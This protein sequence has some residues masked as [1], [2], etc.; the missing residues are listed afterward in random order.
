[1]TMKVVAIR[2]AALNETHASIF[3]RRRTMSAMHNET[4]IADAYR[5]LRRTF[6]G[7][8]PNSQLF[9]KQFNGQ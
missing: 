4:P 9:V 3:V 7:F 2:D 1:M 6:F 8:V 5:R